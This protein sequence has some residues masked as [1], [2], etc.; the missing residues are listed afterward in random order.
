MESNEVSSLY[1]GYG[2]MGNSPQIHQISV[3]KNMEKSS[4]QTDP[5]PPSTHQRWCFY[6]VLTH[7]FRV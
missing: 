2:H 7:N 5:D 3:W 1:R 6:I 4:I